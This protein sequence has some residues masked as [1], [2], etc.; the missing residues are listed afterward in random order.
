MIYL[1]DSV[2]KGDRQIDA[3]NEIPHLQSFFY[4]IKGLGSKSQMW[5]DKIQKKHWQV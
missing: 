4:T 2:K 5:C 1:E 3:S